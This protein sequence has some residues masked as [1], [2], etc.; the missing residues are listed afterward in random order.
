MHA[1][2]KMSLALLVGILSATAQAE[3]VDKYWGN[4]QQVYFSGKQIEAGPFINLTAPHRAES[5]A[6][7]PFTFSIDYPMTPENYV[8]SVTVIVDGN[9]V[10]LA[11]VFHFNPKSG[12]AEIST[13]IRMEVDALV[14]VVAE[15]SDGKY[16]MNAIPILATGG[17][18]GSIGGD[19]SV[20][21]QTAGKMKLAVEEP[22]KAGVPVKARL[23]IKHPMYTGLQR[24]LVSQGYRPAFFINKI[25]AKFNG[26]TVMQADTFIGISED[27]N[28]QFDFVPEKSGKLIVTIEDNE[29]GQFHHETDVTVQ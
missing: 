10:P 2:I 4:L 25:D 28:I 14:H 23:L 18:G 11:A 19:E 8:K 21:R 12:K 3:V 7:V 16:Y 9:P 17:C 29:N 5:G 27:P 22:T 15:T 20:A 24:D 6:Q 13:R 26:E 1:L